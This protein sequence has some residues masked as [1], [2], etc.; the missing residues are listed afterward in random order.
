MSRHLLLVFSE[1]QGGEEDAYNAWY[2]QRHLNDVVDIDGIED[3]QRFALER[4]VGDLGSYAFGYLAVYRLET[5]D[6]AE[7]RRDM[8]KRAG[9]D[10]MPL[11]PAL[12]RRITAIATPLT[13]RICRDGTREEPLKPPSPNRR[14]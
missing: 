12:G 7:L 3:A 5:D 6:V 2:S 8:V 4:T 14:G 1:P 10:A 11:S 9:T 13:P